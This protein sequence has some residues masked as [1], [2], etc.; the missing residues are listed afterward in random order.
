MWNGRVHYGK[1]VGCESVRVPVQFSVIPDTS[2][3]TFTATKTGPGAFDFDASGSIGGQYDWNFGDGNTAT[4]LQVSHTYTDPGNFTVTLTVTDTACGSDDISTQNIQSTIS[5]EALAFSQSLR[6]YPNP[7]DGHFQVS[8][9][10]EGLQVVSMRLLNPAGQEVLLHNLGRISGNH[11]E[12]IDLK[13][14]ASGIY[15]LQ[16]QTERG[17]VTKRVSI[18]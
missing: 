2:F 1:G 13:Q 7:N 4:G 8:F 3:A 18:L 14:L 11:T 15:L 17:V 16:V 9:D 5:A 12:T 6:V 10:V